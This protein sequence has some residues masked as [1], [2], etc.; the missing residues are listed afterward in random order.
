MSTNVL[1]KCVCIHMPLCAGEPGLI[2]G[3]EFEREV[4]R[5]CYRERQTLCIQAT[6]T[7]VAYCRRGE[8]SHCHIF[9]KHLQL[10]G[11]TDCDA[12]STHV[13]LDL[14]V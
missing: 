5:L 13:S 8:V 12:V 10:E 11:L 2:R 3:A 1:C 6:V 14:S 7:M 9:H 4:D